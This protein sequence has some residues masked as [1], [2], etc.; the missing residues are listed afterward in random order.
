MS[1]WDNPVPSTVDV[2]VALEGCENMGDV[3]DVLLRMRKL[4]ELPVR[5]CPYCG[6]TVHLSGTCPS[7][8][9]PKT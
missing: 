1:F 8:G 3:A 6:D 9:W 4:A 2:I 5:D 7:C